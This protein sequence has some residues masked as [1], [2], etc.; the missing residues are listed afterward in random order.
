MNWLFL[1]VSLEHQPEQVKELTKNFKLHQEQLCDGSKCDI[2]YDPRLTLG[3][4]VA[5]GNRSKLLIAGWFL[6]E[7]TVNNYNRLLERIE[8][9]GLSEALFSI[10]Q[11][12]FIG[13]FDDGVTPHVFVDWFG[14]SAHYLTR[15]GGQLQVAPSALALRSELTPINP[16]HLG[17]I[18][19]KGHIW[20]HRTRYQNIERILP[21]HINSL[22]KQK[23]YI[24]FSRIPAV[25]IAE[26][27]LHIKKTTDAFDSTSKFVSISAGFD[28]RL[29]AIIG[30][31][32]RGYTWGPEQSKDIMNSGV[33]AKKLQL[34]VH[35]F[36]F[37]EE[38]PNADDDV[39]CEWILA[40]QN[41]QLQQ[42]FFV[43]YRK[44]SQLCKPAFVALDG[45]LG[46]V[47]QRGVYLYGSSLRSEI[48]RLFPGCFTRDA[49]IQILR[50]RYCKL[51]D[52]ELKLLEHDY[53]ELLEK[54]NLTG[55]DR[56]NY[57]T[58]F[59]FMFGRGFAHIY[60]GGIALNSVFNVVLPGFAERRIFTACLRSPV[61]EVLKYQVFKNT[62]LLLDS[63]IVRLKSE[64][65]YSPKTSQLFIPFANF[66]GRVITNYLPKYKNYGK[67]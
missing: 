31:A 48:K 53:T 63:D 23:C 29:L 16:V 6:L 13:I 5:H 3:K 36:R 8:Q 28:S 18:E 67:E 15:V 54:I 20:G 24:D 4:P 50:E 12:V 65:L 33:I 27:P 25:P 44:A 30:N 9:N 7:G 14:L 60:M 40:G 46:D 58:A 22:D 62:W 42:Q 55:V 21:G 45:Y 10:E 19:K 61:E 56:A 37:K 57:V 17:I 66:I 1:N 52:K 51:S 39:I 41:K 59:E 34:K 38:Q 49:D 26:I 47:L 2:I 43:N 32:S 35:H 64:G 11:G